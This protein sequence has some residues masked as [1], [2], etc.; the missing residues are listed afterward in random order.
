TTLLFPMVRRTL[1]AEKYPLQETGPRPLG[2]PVSSPS[3][4]V[5]SLQVIGEQ[6]RHPSHFSLFHRREQATMLLEQSS[7]GAVQPLR[8]ECNQ[9]VAHPFAESFQEEGEHRIA[10]ALHQREVKRRIRVMVFG[11]GTARLFHH[12]ERFVRPDQSFRIGRRGGQ[13][14]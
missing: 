8:K 4:S 6:V 12:L 10:G 11:R 5:E 1:A 14:E 3:G 13:L 9:L 7:A 2:T